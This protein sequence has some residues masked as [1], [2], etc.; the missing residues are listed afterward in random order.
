VAAACAAAGATGYE[1]PGGALPP[2]PVD[3]ETLSRLWE[4][5]ALLA[6]PVLLV[7]DGDGTPDSPGPEVPARF[8]A[9]SRG[10]IV[11][12][13]RRWPAA[14]ARE[15]VSFD[16]PAPTVDEQRAAWADGLRAPVAG[17]LTDRLVSQFRLSPAA[18][19]AVCAE[20]ATTAA[21]GGG[22]LGAVAW[23]VCM[24]RSRPR[25]DGL[26]ARVSTTAAWDDLVLPDAQRRAL[27]AIVRQVRHR[28]RVQHNWGFGDRDGGVSALFAGGS[29]T[30]KT[31]AASILAAELGLDLFRVDLSGVVSKYIGDTEKNLGRV[32]DAAEESGVALLF[33]EADALFGKRSGV[34][35]S[36]DRYANIEVSYLLQRMESYRGLA[37]LTTNLPDAL[38]A[39][40]LRR[41]RFI[42]RFPFPDAGQR[43]EIWR[44]A[45]PPETPT[46]G[47]DPVRLASLEIAGGGIRNIALGAAFHAADAGAPVGMAHILAATLDESEKLQRPLMPNEVDGWLTR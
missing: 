30:G 42:V 19:H 7:T 26:A 27:L 9:R 2:T 18:I 33:D 41:L 16:V 45:F 20:A 10:R 46:D 23:E 1:L 14:A 24:R 4:R 25:L 5:E 44:R 17:D 34:R 36:H 6:G 40:F 22:D 37:I 38:D 31:M 43:A 21:T 8:A 11:Y 39:A 28:G 3:L 47:I 29:G 12:A 32:F 15:V 13:G 35:D